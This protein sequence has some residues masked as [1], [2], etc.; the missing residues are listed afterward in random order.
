VE[1]VQENVITV[2]WMEVSGF[3]SDQTG[4]FPQK[5]SN[6]GQYVTIAYNQDSNEI[7]AEP[8]KSRSQHELVR[9]MKDIHKYLKQQGL[10]PK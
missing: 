9:A 2:K 8:I 6:R 1:T 7:L 4:R 3:F 10:T 5:S